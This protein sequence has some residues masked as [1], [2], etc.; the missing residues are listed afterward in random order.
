[1][2]LRYK[3]CDPSCRT[4]VGPNAYGC[5][6]YEF[7]DD[8]KSNYISVGALVGIVAAAVI[9]TNVI[10]FAV[11]LCCCKRWCECKAGKSKSVSV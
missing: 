3:Q 8:V 11:A 1:M 10:A 9:A 7:D 2:E 5:T 4:C 6:E